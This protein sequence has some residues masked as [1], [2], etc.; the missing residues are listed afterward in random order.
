MRVRNLQMRYEGWGRSRDR[1]AAI[2]Q[3]AL[4]LIAP[5]LRGLPGGNAGRLQITV[6]APRGLDDAA[7]AAR[8][9]G[10]VTARVAE[11]R[12]R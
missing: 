2:S 9:A 6:H 11:P 4:A 10:A 8:I 12:S 3:R 7:L 5:Q 1:T